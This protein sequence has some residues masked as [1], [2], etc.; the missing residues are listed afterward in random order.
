M[1]VSIKL[2]SIMVTMSLQIVIIYT[3]VLAVILSAA[4]YVVIYI[5]V[6]SLTQGSKMDKLIMLADVNDINIT[7]TYCNLG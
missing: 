7:G 6:R 2:K 1:K 3:K 5:N 4:C